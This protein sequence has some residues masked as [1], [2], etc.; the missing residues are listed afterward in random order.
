MFLAMRRV[1]RIG[2]D[3]ISNP[4]SAD[5]PSDHALFTVHPCQMRALL[6]PI[7]RRPLS[8][9]TALPGHQIARRS[10]SSFVDREWWG[11]G[12][13]I[14]PA[15]FAPDSASLPWGFVSRSEYYDHLGELAGAHTELAR[16]EYEEL[17]VGTLEEFEEGAEHAYLYIAQAYKEKDADFFE[18]QGHGTLGPGLAALFTDT[19]EHNRGRGAP[20]AGEAVC[21]GAAD[22]VVATVLVVRQQPKMD[23]NPL[24]DMVDARSVGG[25]FLICKHTVCG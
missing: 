2:E 11:P 3:Q 15:S 7:L 23:H 16:Q 24:G 4:I 1:P 22:E 13:L 18:H 5:G 17:G 14:S 9:A 19:L 8:H 25:L 12:S 6:R 10:L 21:K 20:G